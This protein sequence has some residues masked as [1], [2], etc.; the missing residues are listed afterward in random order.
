[1]PAVPVAACISTD[2]TV[3]KVGNSTAAFSLFLPNSIR[4]VCVSPAVQVS[5]PES[6]YDFTRL[7]PFTV[8]EGYVPVAYAV[9]AIVPQDP[10][11]KSVRIK[12]MALT[13]VV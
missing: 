11:P 2:P 1:M 10:S 12:S 5:D 3:F 13:P 7:K 8:D 9:V 4:F 6:K